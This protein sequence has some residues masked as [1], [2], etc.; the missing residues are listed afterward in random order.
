MSVTPTCPPRPSARQVLA[1]NMR[2]LRAQRGWS[3]EELSFECGMD[4]S[5]LAHVE[6]CARNVS[7]DNIDRIAAAFDLPIAE[8][9]RVDV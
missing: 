6:R 8:L 7:L 4:R 3:Q 1:D 2:R 9:F 5:F